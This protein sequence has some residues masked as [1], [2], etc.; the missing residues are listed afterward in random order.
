MDDPKKVLFVCMG[1]IC[2]SPTGEGLLQQLV[3]EQGLSETV[4]VDSAGTIDYHVG[5][6]ADS[7]MRSAAENRGYNLTSRARQV[8]RTD[9]DHFDLVIAMD[10]ENLADLTSLASAP[11]A[12]IKLL[13]E[14]LDDEWP[15]DV[16]DPY[17]GGDE[18]FEYVLDMIKQAC[19]AILAEL[20]EP[21]S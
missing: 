21:N 12:T 1:N 8:T 19:P 14:Y 11:Q 13:S 16:P 3:D 5:K 9:L 20:I 7:R 17:Y 18:G 4:L 6:Q 15:V 10:R 2:R